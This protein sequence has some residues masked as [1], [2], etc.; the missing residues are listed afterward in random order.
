MRNEC[1]ECFWHQSPS[2]DYGLLD[3]KDM[4]PEI[5]QGYTGTDNSIVLTNLE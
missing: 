2:S 3:I 1:R 5:Y 4:N